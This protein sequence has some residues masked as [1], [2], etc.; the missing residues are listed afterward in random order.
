MDRIFRYTDIERLA[1]TDYV[2]QRLHGFLDGG[3]TVV[4]MAVEDV[5]IF[6]AHTPQA[7]V[8]RCHKTLT[9]TAV[10][11]YS[12][13]HGMTSLRGNEHFVAMGGK[14]RTEYASEVFLGAPR[15]WTV[16]VGKVEMA[17][18]GIEGGKQHVARSIVGIDGTEIV[19][20]A[21]RKCRNTDTAPAA[22]IIFHHIAY[23]GVEGNIPK[24]WSR[25]ACLRTNCFKDRLPCST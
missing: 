16:I 4:T 21:Q 7:L 10:A 5:D 2:D 15:L 9:R 25:E 22:Q 20:K 1:G 12:R 17:N 19:P 13:P 8:A 18:A 6:E 3:D 14:I 24:M 23:M 11:V